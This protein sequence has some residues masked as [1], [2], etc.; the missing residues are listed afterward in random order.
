MLELFNT[1]TKKLEEFVPLK[2]GR[3]SF[4]HCGPTVYWTQHIGN[5]RAMVMADLIRRTLMYLDYEVEFVRNYTDVG[6][7]VSD[8][9]EGED[10]MEKG[11]K[12]DKTTPAEIAKRYIGIF[13]QDTSVLNIIEPNYKPVASEY[14]QQMIEM[15]Q[16]LLDKGM[17][18]T[19]PKAIYFDISQARDYTRLSGQKLELNQEGAGFGTID[20]SDN[21]KHPADFSLWFFRTGVHKNAIQWWKSPFDSPEVQ[22]G[23]GFPGWHIECSAMARDL[24]GDTI[25]IHMGGI[26]HI[27]VH[28]TNEIA[29]SEGVTG[30]KFV[31]YWLHNEHLN[32]DGGKMSK[33]DGTGYILEDIVKKGYDPIDLRYFFLQ[34]HYR[35]SQ[36]L[37]WEALDAAR[38]GLANLRNRIAG[39]GV[40]NREQRVE[41]AGNSELETRSLKKGGANSKFRNEKSVSVKR[42]EE[43]GRWNIEYR[44]MFVN[45]LQQDINVP[46]A[47][48]VVWDLLK[49]D[50]DDAEKMATVLDFDRVL[51]LQLAAGSGQEV[52]INDEVQDLLDKRQKARDSKDWKTSDEIRDEIMSSFG[53]FVEDT[54][55]GQILK[56]VD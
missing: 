7:L 12:R 28:H 45:Y 47:L 31:N 46:G 39:L 13:E 33:S 42:Q 1:E 14:V 23:A 2:K 34:A 37:T 15:V 44:E 10:K 52:E 41:E 38:N 30:K 43:K 40:E 48:S 9:D 49:S 17:A 24:L 32:V 27:P 29:Q 6:H 18:Y 16:V 5:L 21:K 3:V 50:V 56:E 26:E 54:Q 36:N 19:T 22:D 4:Y 35:S 51:G 55:E 53:L 8:E 20:D 25:D 11:A